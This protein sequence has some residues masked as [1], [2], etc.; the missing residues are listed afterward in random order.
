[1]KGLPKPYRDCAC[2][3]PETSRPYAKGNCPRLAADNRHGAW[4]A[5]YSAPAAPGKKRSQPRI[6]PFGTERACKAALIA[7]LG[8][9]SQGRP[10]DDRRTK[11]H[12]HLDRRLRWWESESSIKPSTLDSYREAINLYLKPALGHV[13]LTDLRDHDFRDLAAAMRLINTPEADKDQ[14]DLMRRLLAARAV[15]DGKRISTRPLTE[16]R[17][18]RVLAVASSALSDLVPH[19]LAVNPAARVK[20]GRMR[21]VK[22]LLWTEARVA[23]WKET[24][25]VP[26]RVMV[27]GRD[28]CGCFLDSIEDERL[29]ALFHLD[30]YYGLRRSEL[31]GLCWSDVDLTTRRL[32]IRVAQVDDELDST[33]S[34]D[35]DRIVI[36]DVATCDALKAWR[37][38]QLQERLAWGAEWTDSGRVFTREDGTPLRPAWI[39]QRF[40]ALTARA[41]LPPVRFHDLRHGACTM[42]LAA[43]VPIKVISEIMGHATSAFTADIYTE[44][45]EELAEAAAVA[46]ASFIPRKGRMAAGSANIVP[47]GGVNDH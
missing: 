40:E 3:D 14:S 34:E 15:R 25:E 31:A 39:S 36:F 10:V 12:E 17:I 43:G 27:W 26:G 28:H 38:I 30:A 35:S 2:R 37:K 29:Y 11:F 19:V 16:A 45:A 32:H 4:Y 21:R 22:P 44:V 9:A 46:I 41:E 20:V 42:L 24:G 1:M 6:G 18:R 23:R 13:K 5:R 33:K 8:R 7:A 47:T